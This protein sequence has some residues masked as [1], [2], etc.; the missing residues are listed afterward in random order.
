MS[1]KLKIKKGDLVK[2]ISGEAKGET[3][4]VISVN[5]ENNRVLVEGV[6]KV[7]KHTKPNA[8]HPNGGIVE[9]EATLHISNLMLMDGA[10]K[11]SRIGRKLDE[12]SNKIVRFYKSTGEVVK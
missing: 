3:G 8:K 7:K 1:I 12:K 9:Q 6:N 2:V 4:K 5:K 10:G 11:A